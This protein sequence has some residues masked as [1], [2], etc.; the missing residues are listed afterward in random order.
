MGFPPVSYD[1]LQVIWSPLV[2][3]SI[4]TTKTK[5][6]AKR[7]YLHESFWRI[8]HADE[9]VGELVLSIDAQRGNLRCET[10]GKNLAP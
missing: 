5:I 2:L 6:Y 1:L 7:V 8:D 10:S 9:L 4:K 3:F